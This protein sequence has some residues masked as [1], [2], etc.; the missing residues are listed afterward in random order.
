M[1]QGDETSQLVV[2][3]TQGAK[4]KVTWFLDVLIITSCRFL[5][6]SEL[7]FAVVHC[8]RCQNVDEQEL[9][10]TIF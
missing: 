3:N 9:R 7:G 1:F 6:L 10:A 4:H 2:L 5:L 8:V